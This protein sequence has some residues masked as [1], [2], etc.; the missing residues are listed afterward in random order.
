MTAEQIEKLQNIKLAI[1]DVDGVLTDGRLFYGPNGEEHKVFH[2]HDGHG[3]K[4]LIRNGIQVAIISGRDC[5][6]LRARLNDLGIEHTYLGQSK[7]IPALN[8]LLDKTG[9]SLEQTC[10]S[11]DD[12]PDL[13]PMQKV[14]FAF[15]PANA[16]NEVKQTA[17]YICH[18]SGGHGAVR[19]ICD[20][21]LSTLASLDENKQ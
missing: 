7:K 5:E 1:F 18:A 11:G 15:A 2:V 4:E 17:N 6:A 13:K 16:I 10:Y 9:I 12:I 14:S 20:L 21:I 8:D 19:E 3:L